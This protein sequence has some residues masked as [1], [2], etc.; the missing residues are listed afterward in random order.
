LDVDVDVVMDKPLLIESA[1]DHS[2]PD[3]PLPDIP[4]PDVPLPEASPGCLV[5]EELTSPLVA[6]GAMIVPFRF[7][8]GS[9]PVRV[10][11]SK[12]FIS[13]VYYY[14]YHEVFGSLKVDFIY[15]FSTGFIFIGFSLLRVLWNIAHAAI[16]Q[17]PVCK[18]SPCDAVEAQY[19]C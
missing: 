17:L 3:V 5:R 10:L 6:E 16:M 7:V 1:G 4:L 15:R 13:G 11:C 8:S 19:V 18:D 12:L 9:C 14:R 2:L